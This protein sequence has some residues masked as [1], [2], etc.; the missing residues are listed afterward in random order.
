MI[1]LEI[2]PPGFEPGSQAFFLLSEIPAVLIARS[3]SCFLLLS[4]KKILLYTCQLDFHSF[5][6][7]LLELVS[8]FKR[9]INFYIFLLLP[10]FLTAPGFFLC[11]LRCRQIKLFRTE[12][13]NARNVL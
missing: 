12:F 4:L 6:F 9:F 7:S 10:L 2:A 1:K 11:L 13:S 8:K 5:L 3:N